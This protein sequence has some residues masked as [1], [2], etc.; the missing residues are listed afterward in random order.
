MHSSRV[1]VQC[2]VFSVF[3]LEMN[4]ATACVSPHWPDPALDQCGEGAN[5]ALAQCLMKFPAL[6]QRKG[7]E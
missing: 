4:D 1:I 5:P 6:A 2:S 3:S 7:V